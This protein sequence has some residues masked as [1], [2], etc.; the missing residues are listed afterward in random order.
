MRKNF[1][2][3]YRFYKFL[4]DLNETPDAAASPIYYFKK[5]DEIELDINDVFCYFIRNKKDMSFDA[6]FFIKSKTSRIGVQSIP[7]C[8]ITLTEIEIVAAVF[9]E[10][11]HYLAEGIKFLFGDCLTYTQKM[12]DAVN[13]FEIAKR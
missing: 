7:I 12:F 13:N 2:E 1:V 3:K 4:E 6:C 9:N 8:Q 5:V 10:S 11:I